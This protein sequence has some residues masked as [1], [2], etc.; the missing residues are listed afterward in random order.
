MLQERERET[1]VR[2]Q[3]HLDLLLEPNIKLQQE[4]VKLQT[5]RKEY[6]LQYRN[7]PEN[8]EQ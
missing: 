8:T 7:K 6:K 1:A 2:R 4:S 3:Q 5:P